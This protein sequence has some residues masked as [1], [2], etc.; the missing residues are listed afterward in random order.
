MEYE[1]PGKGA[2]DGLSCS[3]GENW[4]GCNADVKARN[5]LEPGS[6]EGYSRRSTTTAN[7]AAI[8][9]AMIAVNQAK[10][11]KDTS[12]DS[13]SFGNSVT[14][15]RRSRAFLCSLPDEEAGYV[16]SPRVS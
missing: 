2:D 6:P 12:L 7:L 8:L 15:E 14:T 5:Y 11:T 10:S 13:V 1:E 3:L 16:Q 4:V 9:E